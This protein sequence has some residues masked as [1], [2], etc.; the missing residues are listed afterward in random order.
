M[1]DR[2]ALVTVAVATAAVTA[3]GCLAGWRTIAGAGLG[4]SFGL[5]GDCLTAF[6]ARRLSWDKLA[7]RPR[8]ST[9]LV[10]LFAI[11]KQVVLVVL[12]YLLLSAM[13]VSVAPFIIAFLAYHAVRLGVMIA[14]PSRYAALISW[15][16]PNPP[17]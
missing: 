6:F 10:P 14:S 9:W 13:V 1:T 17:Q 7:E 2:T 15:A 11:G 16:S 12:A 5:L 3:A 4:L 8:R